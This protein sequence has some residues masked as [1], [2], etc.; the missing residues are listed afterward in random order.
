MLAVSA[1]QHVDT[2]VR[3]IGDSVS[4]LVVRTGNGMSMAQELTARA[5]SMS[6]KTADARNEATS[7]QAS[8]LARLKSARAGASNITRAGALNITQVN[9]ISETIL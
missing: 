7:R 8:S 6:D 2:A 4:Q 1:T 5:E 3:D 9:L